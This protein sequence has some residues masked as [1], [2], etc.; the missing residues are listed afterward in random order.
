[1]RVAILHNA[2]PADAPPEDQDTLVQVEA[3]AHALARLGHE[4]TTLACTL[5]LA[6]MREKLLQQR[7]E[8][9]F[10]LV[11]SL[12]ES[13]S[14]AYLPL[15]VLDAIEL[16][17]AGNRTEAQFLTAHKV[18]AKHRMLE[19]GLP[20]PAWIEHPCS[21]AAPGCEP[22]SI[23]APGCD[24]SGCER[25]KSQPRAAVPQWIV[26]G[27]WDQGSRGMDD[28]AVLKGLSQAEVQ[29]RLARR[30]DQTGRP[31]FAE[32]YIEG[33]EFNLAMLADRTGPQAL[34]PAEIDFAAYPPDK[35][36]IVGHRAKWQP[37]SFEYHHTVRRFDFPQTDEPLLNR[38]R[39]CA[40]RCWAVFQLRGWVRV[41]FRVDSA[42]RPWIL[43]VNTNPCLSPDAGFAAAVARASL[44]FDEAIRRILEDAI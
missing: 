10:N 40:L 18:F 41:D 36:R 24:V 34:P 3:V 17:Y 5:D 21:T 32:E 16:P 30:T 14:L 35:P 2:V 38:L 8:V 7:P 44:S 4:S 28:D 12:A 6:A 19:A 29:E 26:K 27:L 33:R 22:C 43:E 23:A 1:M 25:H 37:D 39:Q 42:G 11:E 15:A 9:V 13:D 20:T 31:C